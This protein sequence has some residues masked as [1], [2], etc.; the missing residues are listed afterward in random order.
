[1]KFGNFS[2]VNK[3]NIIVTGDAHST[4]ANDRPVHCNT[5]TVSGK[6][7]ATLTAIRYYS[8]KA[9]HVCRFTGAYSYVLIYIAVYIS[10]HCE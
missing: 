10:V 6:H 5:N 3:K 2:D 1:M 4:S 8:L 7:S 9:S